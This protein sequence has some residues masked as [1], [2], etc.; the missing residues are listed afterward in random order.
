MRKTY[1]K[2]S[3]FVQLWSHAEMDDTQLINTTMAR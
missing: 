2:N 1:P 3:K